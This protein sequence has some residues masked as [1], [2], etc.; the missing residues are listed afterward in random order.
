[1]APPASSETR[2]RTGRPSTTSRPASGSPSPTGSHQT[3]AAT[4]A[5]DQGGERRQRP[6]APGAAEPGP[7]AGCRAG[8]A[9]VGGGP[10]RSSRPSHD[11]GAGA[12]PDQDGQADA[13]HPG[14]QPGVRLVLRG[15]GARRRGRRAGA[16]EP[17]R[18]MRCRGARPDAPAGR[19]RPAP[20][21]AS[22]GE[23][24][25]PVDR[26]AVGGDDPVGRPELPGG[27]RLA[28]TSP[29]RCPRRP[30][31]APPRR[32]LSAATSVRVTALPSGRISSPKTKRDRRRGRRQ[33]GPVLR[34][35]RTRAR[36]APR[37]VP[38]PAASASAA[39]IPTIHPLT[40]WVRIRSLP[41]CARG[42]PSGPANRAQPTKPSRT[43][44][45]LGCS[46]VRGRRRVDPGLLALGGGDRRRALRSAGRAPPRSSG[47]R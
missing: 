18:P 30:R 39:R 27:A 25:R 4:A 9:G 24:D 15:R 29:T 6:T 7:P 33:G 2:R 10:W 19:L 16:A 21:P 1:M 34:D 23:R 20:R 45:G 40:I 31:P 26:M 17:G 3:P 41:P 8:L 36:R 43:R 42:P 38:P 5:S 14:Q 47:T 22:H 13:Q 12:R 11:P 32:R 35:P 28:A 44:L 46:P 37:R